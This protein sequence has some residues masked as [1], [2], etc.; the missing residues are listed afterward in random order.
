MTNYLIIRIANKPDGST[1][2][3]IQHFKDGIQAEK[4]FYRLCGLAVDSVNISDTVI[5]MTT[6]GEI[7]QSKWFYHPAEEDTTEP[8]DEG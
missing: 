3:P 5:M 8:E 4:E 1:S 2:S 7:M 6:R